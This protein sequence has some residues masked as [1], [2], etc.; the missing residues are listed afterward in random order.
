MQVR[1]KVFGGKMWVGKDSEEK[2]GR[3]GDQVGMVEIHCIH[4]WN[5]PIIHFQRKEKATV[6]SLSCPWY[7]FIIYYINKP[8]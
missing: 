1:F 4:V 5:L 6:L 7:L 2:Y 8:L 3:E